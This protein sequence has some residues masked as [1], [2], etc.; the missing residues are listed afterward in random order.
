MLDAQ[1]ARG[2]LLGE[3][4]QSAALELRRMAGQGRKLVHGEV[5]GVAPA[6]TISVGAGA[7]E[8]KASGSA[9]PRIDVGGRLAAVFPGCPRSVVPSSSAAS[10][11]RRRRSDS[12]LWS[13]TTRI[14][15]GGIVT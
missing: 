12:A 10:S 8:P 5:A 4:G 11:L 7:A 9:T 1:Q 15:P 3:A 14:E 2:I 13:T 6:S